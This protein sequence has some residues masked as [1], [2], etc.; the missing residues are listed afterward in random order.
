MV[1]ESADRV[2]LL[3]SKP[4]PSC[5]NSATILHLIFLIFLKVLTESMCIQYLKQGLAH[6]KLSLNG[7][8]PL[9]WKLSVLVSYLNIQKQSRACKFTAICVSGLPQSSITLI[10]WSRPLLLKNSNCWQ[11]S[12]WKVTGAQNRRQAELVLSLSPA[13]TNHGTLT[14]LS[15]SFVYYRAVVRRKD[16][17]IYKKEREVALVRQ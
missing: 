12:C 8:T 14:L 17:I 2:R 4:G 13:F 3:G 6:S 16:E 1:A 10:R 7:A 9:F 15:L 11:G 5:V